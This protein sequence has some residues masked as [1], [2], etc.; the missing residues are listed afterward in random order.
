MGKLQ[1]SETLSILFKQ[2]ELF[3]V[4]LA[5]TSSS[6]GCVS[7]Y[8]H[9][10][11][12]EPVPTISLDKIP[13]FCE[14]DSILVHAS[15]TDNYEWSDG[16]SSNSITIKNIGDYSVIGISNNGCRDSL[17][18][19]AS[20][21]DNLGYYI[22]ADKDE[23]SPDQNTVHFSTESIQ[24]SDYTWHFGDG[25]KGYASDITHTYDITN[26]GLYNVRLSVINPHG[27]V[28]E[29]STQ[30]SINI[31]SIPNTFTPNGDGFNDFYLIGWHIKIYNRNGIL[32]YEGDEGWDGTY[33]GKPVANDTYFAILYDSSET[34]N[35]Y[36]TNYVTVLR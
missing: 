16:T 30:I 14:G 18:F 27:C 7:T 2:Q 25:F 13:Q 10:I 28:E 9:V 20:F 8:D 15:G 35:K 12:V 31:E 23:V 22:Y 33:N 36:R 4:Q 11:N 1:W 21:F 5:V 6:T 3:K 24:F 26:D 34:G 19:R 17:N 29:D 32:L